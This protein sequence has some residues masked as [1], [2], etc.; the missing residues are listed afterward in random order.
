MLSAD[1]ICEGQTTRM[2]SSQDTD[3]LSLDHDA[4]VLAVQTRG[5]SRG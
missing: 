3:L 1:S 2:S 4:R 5:S